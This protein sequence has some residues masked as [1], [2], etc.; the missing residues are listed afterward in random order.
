MSEFPD[1]PWD[2]GIDTIDEGG[3]TVFSDVGQMQYLGSKKVQLFTSGERVTFPDFLINDEPYS[4]GGMK[5]GWAQG[6]NRN[7]A[8]AHF[9]A[10][11]GLNSKTNE[12]FVTVRIF[13][14]KNNIRVDSNIIDQYPVIT[15]D[16]KQTKDKEEGNTVWLADWSNLQFPALAASLSVKD[17]TRFGN[18][19]KLYFKADNWNTGT[20]PQED[21]KG[22]TNDDGKIK[23]YYDR[24]WFN[25]QL[26]DNEAD[27]L[28][29]R[30][31]NAISADSI[32]PA[33]WVEESSVED[34]L[35]QAK[36][37]TYE[38]WSDLAF[39]MG[40][41]SATGVVA[42]IANGKD[43]DI[44]LII[45]KMLDMPEAM[46]RK[47]MQPQEIEEGKIPF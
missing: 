46:I 37:L 14:S 1:L 39:Q 30:T 35:S 44:P 23:K 33:K 42:K 6:Q 41:I 21:Y 45:S 31:T 13:T 47:E 25:I 26:F 10:F 9:I 4:R 20:K 38:S 15:L 43:V 22:R 34:R 7:N 19:E 12:P 27:M 32:Y 29:A 36:N 28:A 18:G 2:D 40:L 16:N 17:R 11:S 24:Y 3:P 8:I 5:E